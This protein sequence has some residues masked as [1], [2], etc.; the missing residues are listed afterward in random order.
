MRTLTGTASSRENGAIYQQ[1]VVPWF[2]RSGSQIEEWR[3]SGVLYDGLHPNQCHLYE[4]KGRYGFVYEDA[5]AYTPAATP[6]GRF[7]LDGMKKQYDN[8]YSKL[9]PYLYKTELHW[10]L[11]TFAVWLEMS[12]YI[13]AN[14]YA[15]FA[16]AQ[17]RPYP[18]W[19]KDD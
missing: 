12:Q 13:N 3:F 4:A 8:Q 2:V 10:V 16:S 11:H 5:S 17:H 7:I 18:G 15:P 9:T 6:F 1:F 14:Q 19:N